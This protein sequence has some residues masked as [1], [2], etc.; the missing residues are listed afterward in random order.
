MRSITP[1]QRIITINVNI[2]SVA[3]RWNPPR[4]INIKITAE[5]YF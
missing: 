5:V 2:S 4:K 1:A 3:L